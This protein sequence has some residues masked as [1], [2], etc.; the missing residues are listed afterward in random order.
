DE[1]PH[2]VG[3]CALDV[4]ARRR[5][6]GAR[7]RRRAE[8]GGRGG[9][10]CDL[11]VQRGASEDGDD[12][13]V[14]ADHPRGGQ[15]WSLGRQLVGH[16]YSTTHWLTTSWARLSPRMISTVIGPTGSGRG[17]GA[18]AGDAV[19]LARRTMGA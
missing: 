5:G 13:D 8:G 3:L 7:G 6:R 4:H 18:G 16:H 12:E 2:G 10:R 1:Q 14:A 17:A 15:S 9:H 19:L 11:R